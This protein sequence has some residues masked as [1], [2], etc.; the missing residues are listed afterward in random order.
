MLFR[1]VNT[2]TDIGEDTQRVDFVFAVDPGPLVYVRK[3]NIS[4][5]QATRDE[6]IRREVRQLESS[7]FS[8]EKIRRSRE[9]IRRLGFSM[10]S[11]LKRH[12]FPEL[13]IRLIWLSLLRSGRL[14]ILCLAPATQTLTGFFW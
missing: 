5:N 4:G 9:R 6:V 3:I 11:I 7:V 8:A 14:V 2:I 13:L 1:S 10:M 12:R